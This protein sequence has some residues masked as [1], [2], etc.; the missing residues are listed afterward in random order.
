M[1]LLFQIVILIYVFED[2]ICSFAI[3]NI[4]AKNRQENAITRNVATVANIE[5]DDTIIRTQSTPIVQST[6]NENRANKTTNPSWNSTCLN[7]RFR[8]GRESILNYLLRLQ[9]CD[10]LDGGQRLPNA[11]DTKKEAVTEY[12]N[13]AYL[14]FCHIFVYEN[15][16]AKEIKN[17]RNVDP[18]L[19][20][21]INIRSEGSGLDS[22]S[23]QNSGNAASLE[24]RVTKFFHGQDLGLINQACKS[25]EDYME[26]LSRHEVYKN[27]EKSFEFN[28]KASAYSEKYFE[29]GVKKDNVTV[30]VVLFAEWYFPIIPF[31][32]A[33]TCGISYEKY[34]EEP[35]TVYNCM[36]KYCRPMVIFS[37]VFDAI[38]AVLIILANSLVLGVAARTKI[39]RNIPG[40]F[41]ISLALADIVVGVFVLPTCIFTTYTMYIA[42]LPFRYPG[43]RPSLSDYMVRPLINFVGFFVVL[44][45]AVSIYTMA[46]ASIDR[47]LAITKPFQYR[48]GAYL[49][50]KRCAL[51]FALI[52]FI[53]ILVAVYPFF[54]NEPYSV[55]AFNLILSAGITSSIVYAIALLV[56]LLAVWFLN[57]AMLRQVCADGEKRRSIRATS[58]IENSASP[59]HSLKKRQS[60]SS[61]SHIENEID[62]TNEKATDSPVTTITDCNMGIETSQIEKRTVTRNVST[63]SVGYHKN[64]KRTSGTVGDGIIERMKRSRGR[65]NISSAFQKKPISRQSSIPNSAASVERRLARTLSIM[66]GA[67]TLAL[68]PNIATMIANAVASGNNSPKTSVR[69]AS[70]LYV[71]SRIL[72]SNS[73]WNC[74]IYSIRNRHFRRAMWAIFLCKKEKID[75][76]LRQSLSMSQWKRRSAM[77]SSSGSNSH[78]K[79]PVSKTSSTASSYQGGDYRRS[80]MMWSLASNSPCPSRKGSSDV[81]GQRPAV[82]RSISTGTE[83]KKPTG[84]LK[85]PI[86]R[87]ESAPESVQCTKL[88]IPTVTV[89]TIQEHA[90]IAER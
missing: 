37:I 36:P 80:T 32:E 34:L 43:Q 78:D 20:E 90:D 4:N 59:Q 46:V 48:Q 60:S 5:D 84:I 22:I 41:K 61:N 8:R 15:V 54:T 79:L 25:I 82:S 57:G 35:M 14:K 38:L 63:S 10:L 6:N 55:S 86:T 44:S 31:C 65:R 66:I 3:Q 81:L 47:Y 50:K 68:M 87:S 21:N 53:G 33:F 67:F 29:E 12:Y 75:R 30:P 24:R 19:K 27:T 52:W 40:Y 70:T 28:L 51:A 56:P 49:T 64:E 7:D 2:S 89:D 69:L 1:R 17:W 42:P 13:V 62:S 45:F 74:I 58:V 39:M 72:L 26:T 71:A 76:K 16:C 11:C 9:L 77:G 18:F 88:I 85:N 83:A 73:F 23:L